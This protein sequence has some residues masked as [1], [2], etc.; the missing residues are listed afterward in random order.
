MTKG[1]AIAIIRDGAEERELMSLTRK[2]GVPQA[3]A[4]RAQIILAAASGLNDEEVAAKV[5]VCAAT[6]GTWRNPAAVAH[7]TRPGGTP[8]PRLQAKRNEIAICRARCEGRNHPRQMHGPAPCP[9]IPQVPR[10][11]RAQCARRSRCAYRHGQL[12]HSQDQADPRLVRQAPA[13]ACALY[14]S[15]GVMD[16]PGRTLLCASHSA[17]SQSVFEKSVCHGRRL[18]SVAVAAMVMRVS[19]TVVSCS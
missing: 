9:G 5:G 6:A 1:R 13:L 14:A 8:H 17:C 10:R 4:E 15:I 12:R 3:L 19:A 2:H 18:I 7:A 16:Q 11:G